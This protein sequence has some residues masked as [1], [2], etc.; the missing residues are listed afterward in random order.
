MLVL[1]LSDSTDGARRQLLNTLSASLDPE[2]VALKPRVLGTAAPAVLEVL[3]QHQPVVEVHWTT[4][5]QA[6]L[7]AALTPGK[8][9]TRVLSFTSADRLNERAKTIALPPCFS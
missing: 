2:R 1:S 3:A 9:T 8:W 5:T 7:R 6:T 4:T